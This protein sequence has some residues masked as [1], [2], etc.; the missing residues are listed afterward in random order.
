[1]TRRRW[2]VAAGL[3]LA[4]LLV[5]ELAAP[6][7]AQRA[8]HRALSP[9]VVAEEVAIT[10]LSRPLLPQI[11]VGRVRDVEVVATGVHLGELRVEEVSVALPVVALPWRL[12]GV[13]ALPPARVQA[14]ITAADAR[15]QLWAVTPFGLQPTLALEDGEVV[16]GAPGLGLDARFVPT[17]APE[18]VALVPA[19]GPPSW[20]T[21]LGVALVVELP[22]GVRIDRIDVDQG[23]IRITGSVAL[24]SVDA[25]TGGTCEEPIAT[26]LQGAEAP[27]V[28]AA[29]R[30][31][32]W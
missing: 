10:E 1:M 5:A 3:V 23:L 29:A 17:V 24:D 22:D 7:L 15:A 4:L 20:W 27:V 18:L 31:A 28:A 12:G 14:R 9:C 25:G 30:T 2:V 11:L 8:L 21:S 16:I 13:E 32:G 19:F 6:S 26:A